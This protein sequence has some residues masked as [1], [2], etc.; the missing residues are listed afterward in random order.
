MLCA[1]CGSDSYGRY[2][3]GKWIC[4]RCEKVLTEDE[5]TAAAQSKDEPLR[6]KRLVMARLAEIEKVT[7]KG[8]DAWKDYPSGPPAQFWAGEM[9]ALLSILHDMEKDLGHRAAQN[10][11]L[12][13]V[14]ACGYQEAEQ[15][16]D[17]ERC[18][19]GRP[20]LANCPACA[21]DRRERARMQRPRLGVWVPGIP[22]PKGST[23]SFVSPKT[24]RVVTMSDCK[25]L[26]SWQQ[27]VSTCV[28]MKIEESQITTTGAYAVDLLFVMPRPKSHF[29]QKGVVKRYKKMNAIKKPDIDKLTRA[30]LD[31]LTAC[32]YHDDSQVISLCANKV[33]QADA[34]V[35][36]GVGITVEEVA[37]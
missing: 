20:A 19:H 24:G 22:A 35:E 23:K 26:K 3:D 36:P 28:L 14:C 15:Q 30:V 27:W 6:V 1:S 29:G 31:A 18:S 37:V 34:S 17:C 7:A 4:I 16:D 8:H 21:E 2:P 12:D 13:E 32:V 25:R 33:Y 9:Y 10:R 11:R 5:K